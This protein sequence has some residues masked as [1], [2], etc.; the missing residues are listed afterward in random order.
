MTLAFVMS[1]VCLLEALLYCVTQ[2]GV[3][4]MSPENVTWKINIIISLFFYL[5][6]SIYSVYF[7]ILLPWNF[8]KAEISTAMHFQSRPSQKLGIIQTGCHFCKRFSVIYLL[9]CDMHN[10]SL[11]SVWIWAGEEIICDSIE[12][13]G[14]LTAPSSR[15]KHTE[16]ACPR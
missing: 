4:T 1:G 10:P 15:I 7:C 11:W 5:P 2:C 8:S 6:S 3:L 9:I 12:G 13:L 14:P 16:Y